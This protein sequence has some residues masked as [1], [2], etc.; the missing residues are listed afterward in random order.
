MRGVGGIFFEDLCETPR[1][2]KQHI[3]EFC[4]SVGKLMVDYY[5][6]VIQ[7]NIHKEYN[8]QHRDFQLIRRSRYAEFNLIHDRG[9]KFGLQSKGRIESIFCSLP[10]ECRWR[11]NYSPAVGTRERF[12]ITRYLKPQNWVGVLT[13]EDLVESEVEE[14]ADPSSL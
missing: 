6:W 8:D 10:A 14:T 7:E 3:F 9:T 13:E 5:S 1:Q 4:V 11:Y 12:V 2:T